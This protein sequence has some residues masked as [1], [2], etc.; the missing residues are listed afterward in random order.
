MRARAKLAEWKSDPEAA[1]KRLA[2]TLPDGP[3]ILQAARV[4]PYFGNTGSLLQQFFSS[5]DGAAIRREP[6]FRPMAGCHPQRPL[7][8]TFSVQSDHR[9]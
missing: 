1:M 8:L 2:A 7:T 6:D 9:W 3:D 4:S 5:A